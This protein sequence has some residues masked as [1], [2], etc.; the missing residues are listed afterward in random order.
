MARKQRPEDV[1]QLDA[2]DA[3]KVKRWAVRARVDAAGKPGA[4]PAVIVF[5]IPFS[6]GMRTLALM[7]GPSFAGDDTALRA[8]AN[9]CD[10]RM[11]DSR[12]ACERIDAG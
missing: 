3:L 10:R 2:A 11:S 1:Q 8:L 7:H 4:P 9:D 6:A 5:E 12:H